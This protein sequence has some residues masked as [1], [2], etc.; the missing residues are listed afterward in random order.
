[1]VTVRENAD[2][3]KREDD[4]KKVKFLTPVYRYR[5]IGSDLSM[6]EYFCARLNADSFLNN[7]FVGKFPA[8]QV[9]RQYAGMRQHLPVSPFLGTVRP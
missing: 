6:F 5:R 2:A 7:M 8:W 9:P 4:S 1:M 3:Q